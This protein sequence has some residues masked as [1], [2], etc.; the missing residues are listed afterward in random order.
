VLRALVTDNS[1]AAAVQRTAAALDEDL[2]RSGA[3]VTLFHAQIDIGGGV[4]YVDAG[5]GYVLLRRAD[6]RVEELR[7]WGLPVG[8]DAHERYV[9]GHVDLAPGD[10][11]LI[12]SDGV[13]EARPDVFALP[14]DVAACAAGEGGGGRA[15]ST[16]GCSRGLKIRSTSVAGAPSANASPV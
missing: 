6:G 7:P 14:V 2:A 1:P 13:A 15:A 5:H 3:F 16:T 9:E 8:V 11:L 4:R 10:T 12:Y